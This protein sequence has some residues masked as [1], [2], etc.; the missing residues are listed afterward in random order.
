MAVCSAVEHPA[1]LETTRA[2]G[3]EVVG[4]DRAGRI[5]LDALEAIL[6]G[7][8]ARAATGVANGSVGL[9]G[10]PGSVVSVM[11]A[12][13]ELGTVND[14]AAVSEV[15]RRCAPGA[16]LHTDAVQAAPWLDLGWLPLLR[17][18]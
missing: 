18:W 17:T 8:A 2:L 16:V 13:N 1:V 15:V 14:I 6:S 4:V 11:T 3:G 10:S 9:P 5:D 7:V 12:N